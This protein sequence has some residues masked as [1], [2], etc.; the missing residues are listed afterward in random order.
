MGRDG[1]S[2]TVL[3]HVE[4]EFW[5]GVCRCDPGTQCSVHWINVKAAHFGARMLKRRPTGGGPPVLFTCQVVT[6]SLPFCSFTE[7]SNLSTRTQDFWM[8][9]HGAGGPGEWIPLENVCLWVQ[10]VQWTFQ[11]ISSTFTPSKSHISVLFGVPPPLRWLPFEHSSTKMGSL[12]HTWS[13]FELHPSNRQTVTSYCEHWIISV[14]ALIRCFWLGPL[15]WHLG[16]C[17]HQ[18]LI[19]LLHG[20]FERPSGLSKSPPQH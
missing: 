8:L 7:P 3:K 18:A 10:I 4:V 16:I 17:Q 13:P 20:L 15:C 12:L 5:C 14:K 1:I 11:P 9:A 6:S 19:L 2:Y